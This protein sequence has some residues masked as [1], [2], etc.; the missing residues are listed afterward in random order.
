MKFIVVIE[1]TATLELSFLNFGGLIPTLI[2]NILLLHVVSLDS[3]GY[4]PGCLNVHIADGQHW[5]VL[6]LYNYTHL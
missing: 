1:I 2:I 4:H 5:S 3:V 6:S